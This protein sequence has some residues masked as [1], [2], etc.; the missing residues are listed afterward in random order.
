MYFNLS[1]EVAKVATQMAIS[2]REEEEKLIGKS[3]YMKVE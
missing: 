3:I 2:T 1:M